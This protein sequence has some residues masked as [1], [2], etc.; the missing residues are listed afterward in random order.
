MEAFSYRIMI[1]LCHSQLFGIILSTE[2]GGDARQ[3]C[4]QSSSW[5]LIWSTGSFSPW[6]SPV[7]RAAVGTT[8]EVMPL[9]GSMSLAKTRS[10]S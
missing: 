7:H 5:A 2:D 8:S 6:E 10:S 4:R 1:S 3:T 9:Y